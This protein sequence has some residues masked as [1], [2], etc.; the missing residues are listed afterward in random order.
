MVTNISIYNVKWCDSPC[1]KLIASNLRVRKNVGWGRGVN[2]V[3][4]TL[5][6]VN[7]DIFII[8]PLG[9]SLDRS[10]L[11]PVL[12]FNPCF[13]NQTKPGLLW[14]LLPGFPPKKH[15]YSDFVLLLSLA[16]QIKLE[17]IIY[18]F[19]DFT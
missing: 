9:D 8:Y 11:P 13:P 18:L 12:H 5:S 1:I 17:L 2:T 4:T 15:K 10:Y 3:Y 14:E 6:R 16:L 19:S 7:Q